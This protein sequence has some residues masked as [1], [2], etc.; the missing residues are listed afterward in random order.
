MQQMSTYV[1]LGVIYKENGNNFLV[2]DWTW[3]VPA[4]QDP[5]CLCGKQMGLLS[6]NTF[7]MNNPRLANMDWIVLFLCSGV[8]LH[9]QLLLT[10]W[11]AVIGIGGLN[12]D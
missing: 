8:S 6:W 9:C 1:F 4:W 7:L 3:G 12:F 10:S 2:D 5:D 11:E